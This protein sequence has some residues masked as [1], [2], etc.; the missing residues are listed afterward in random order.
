MNVGVVLNFQN[1]K[2]LQGITRYALAEGWNLVL[3][4]TH[5]LED[6][7]DHLAWKERAIDGLIVQIV[8]RS[9]RQ[10]TQTGLPTV[11]VSDMFP[12]PADVPSVCN[13]N[14]AIG[15]LG[16]EHLLLQPV[17]HFAYLGLPNRH[18]SELRA[19]GFAQ[20]IAR[21]GHRCDVLV[22]NTL[23]EIADWLSTLPKPVGIMAADDT[24]ASRVLAGCRAANIDVREQVALVGVGDTFMI[25]HVTSPTLTSI[26][27]QGE[28][29]GWEAARLLD[30][31]MAAVAQ[32]T[33]LPRPADILVPPVRVDVRES[34]MLHSID[35]ELVE[36]LRL[37]REN[38]V[39]TV[40]DLADRLAVHRRTLERRF[41]AVLGRSPLEEIR[42]ARI[43]TARQLLAGSNMTIAQ[44][45]EACGYDSLK[46]LGQ[47][48]RQV[49]GCTPSAYRRAM[50]HST[51]K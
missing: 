4:S 15:R 33:P 6:S 37:I 25:S 48:F 13:D 45:A 42:L 39:N 3:Q 32:G 5:D 2:G 43:T 34:S 31:M 50:R 29:V 23:K 19:Q 8:G 46:G 11:N 40:D 36:A 16:A 7:G 51:D 28:R 10:I 21:A 14:L 35:A 1:R 18:F 17:S 22:S 12:P 47:A 26:A 27:L 20:T 41:A 49:V 9:T 44:I 24:H 30:R 38:E